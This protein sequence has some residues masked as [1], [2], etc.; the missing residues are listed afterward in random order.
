MVKNKVSK[1][2]KS[3]RIVLN[4]SLSLTNRWL[5][6]F[7]CLLS[8]VLLAVGVY[9]TH[10]TNVPNP[11]HGAHAIQ[12]TTSEGEETTLQQ[13]IDDGKLG[14]GGNIGGSLV[15]TPYEIS[16]ASTQPSCPD[17]NLGSHEFCA[18]TGFYGD[19]NQCKIFIDGN[20]DWILRQ[21][22][23][24]GSRLYCYAHCFDYS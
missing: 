14:G 12:I 3:K 2:K 20:N 24:A 21:S 8:V 11:G 4:F 19:G 17:Q 13:A 18:S 10:Y 15:V 16:C 22:G 23:V 6:V 7:F 5:Y 9:S 1:N